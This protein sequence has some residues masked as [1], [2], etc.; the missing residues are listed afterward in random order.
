MNNVA[1]MSGTGFYPGY[2][3]LFWQVYGGTR[4]VTVSGDIILKD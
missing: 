4:T 2:V 1:G 3:S